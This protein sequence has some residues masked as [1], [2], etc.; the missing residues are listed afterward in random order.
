M[1]YYLAYGSNLNK[2]QMSFRCPNAKAVG[3]ANLN[4]EQ[5]A[6]CGSRSGSYLT[7]IKKE[8]AKTPVAVW[9]VDEIDENALDRYEGYP[10]FYRKE[11]RKVKMKFADGKY[12]TI[13]AFVYV[14]NSNDFSL[15]DNRYWYVCMKGYTDFGFEYIIL[16]K[17]LEYTVKQMEAYL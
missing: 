3:V 17:A 13:T 4:N 14:M 15:P 10:S 8:G 12:K 11:T 16:D 1:S 2:L 5:L 7:I 9:E 6:F